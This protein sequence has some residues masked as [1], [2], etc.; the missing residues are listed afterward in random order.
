MTSSDTT[1][2]T[3]ADR[4]A[5]EAINRRKDPVFGWANQQK[6][7]DQNRWDGRPNPPSISVNN[8]EPRDSFLRPQEYTG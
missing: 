8:D 6:T 3:T 7:P 4:L 1:S 2:S 5:K